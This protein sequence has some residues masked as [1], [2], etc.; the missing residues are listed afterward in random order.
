MRPKL[1]TLRKAF[2][3]LP[4][5][6]PF[7]TGSAH[8]QANCAMAGF[9]LTPVNTPVLA[10]Q[11][12][13]FFTAVNGPWPI[14]WYSNGAPVPGATNTSF[15]TS[16]VTAANATNEYSVGI[17]GCVTSAAVQAQIFT[18]S[19][20][21]LSIGVHF[22]GGGA[23][24]APFPLSPETIA[25]QQLQAFWNECTNGNG[26]T[27][28]TLPDQILLNGVAGTLHVDGNPMTFTFGHVP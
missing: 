16:L 15:T 3:L 11:P 24:G 22:Q 10:G 26:G 21:N 14:Q 27:G 18:P 8:A 4:S 17:V 25:G 1:S 9:M 12:A 13:T 20:T 6:L 7:L 5:L 28:T 19:P 2:W 23:N